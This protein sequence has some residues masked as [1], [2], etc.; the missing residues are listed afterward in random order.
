M[1]PLVSILIPASN[2]AEYIAATLKS[3]VAQ[4]WPHREIIVVDDGSR[5]RT[6]GDR[7]EL[8]PRGVTVV[9]QSNQ[10]RR[11]PATRR[12]MRAG[13][14]FSGWTPTTCWRGED[15]ATDCG[16][17]TG[18]DPRR[19]VLAEWG[20]FMYRP[21]RAEFTPTALW[22]ELS[23]ADWLRLKLGNNLYMQTATWLVSRELTERRPV[24]YGAP[25]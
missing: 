4:T 16:A 21:D 7:E 9:T 23:P 20:R 25:R 15:R 19:P 1:K 17:R 13:R 18:R 3:A 6:L 14:S 24:E 8:Q 11:R 22:S 10:G 12:C 5:D 2:A